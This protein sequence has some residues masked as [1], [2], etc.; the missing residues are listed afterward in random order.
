MIILSGK[1]KEKWLA[2]MIKQ[3]G[4]DKKGKRFAELRT[5]RKK[6]VSWKL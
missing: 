3:S 5:G 6:M 1:D 4:K 2:E